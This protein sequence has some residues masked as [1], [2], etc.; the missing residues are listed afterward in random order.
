M[1]N[2]NDLFSQADKKS[3]GS[4]VTSDGAVEIGST[5]AGQPTEIKTSTGEAVVTVTDDGEFQLSETQAV[6]E[7]VNAI[8]VGA[9]D[10]DK[11]LATVEAIATFVAGAVTATIDFKEMTSKAAFDAFISAGG[12]IPTIAFVTDTTPFDYTDNTGHSATDLTWMFVV[13]VDD[14]GTITTSMINN[15]ESSSL[16][17]DEIAA[18]IASTEDVN[19]VNDSQLFRINNLPDN[20]TDAKW[21]GQC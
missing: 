1:A 18:I 7:I 12:F 2:I 6:R 20:T 21:E 11:K 10:N 3:S 14:E 8:V 13:C 9:D 16:T 15:S 4:G 17:G 19:F 5:V